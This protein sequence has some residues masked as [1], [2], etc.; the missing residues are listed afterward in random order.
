LIYFFL[1]FRHYAR[2]KYRREYLQQLKAHEEAKQTK[3]AEL[4]IL[5]E[6]AAIRKAQREI[7]KNNPA[8]IIT[9]DLLLGTSDK[10]PVHANKEASRRVSDQGT[11][12]VDFQAEIAK[13]IASSRISNATKKDLSKDSKMLQHSSEGKVNF[14][15]FGSAEAP[16]PFPSFDLLPMA[17]LKRTLQFNDGKRMKKK[18]KRKKTVKITEKSSKTSHSVSASDPDF[19]AEEDHSNHERK[20]NAAQ[21]KKNK[22]RSTHKSKKSANVSNNPI[23]TDEVAHSSPDVPFP[24]K[25][26][27][28]NN[29]SE[30]RARFGRNRH[31]S[32]E[33]SECESIIGDSDKKSD[34]TAQQKVASPSLTSTQNSCVLMESAST[35]TVESVSSHA[36]AVMLLGRPAASEAMSYW[37]ERDAKVIRD[38]SR[39]IAEFVIT[40]SLGQAMAHLTSQPVPVDSLSSHPYL[41]SGTV[42][43]RG[44]F[45]D[46]VLNGC[47]ESIYP[48]TLSTPKSSDYFR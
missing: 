14:K 46:R 5:E 21:P 15:P 17:Y 7:T 28:D 33:S 41:A 24:N 8:F 19:K 27:S 35:T 11:K 20:H 23:Q 47:V 40:V 36:A 48:S 3:M 29:L 1:S 25:T 38:A 37:L 18:R 26:D 43:E 10:N 42:S 44:V 16:N 9:S 31:F 22:R 4:R 30:E 13:K 12:V 32:S 39:R 34:K 2:T 6:M 45:E